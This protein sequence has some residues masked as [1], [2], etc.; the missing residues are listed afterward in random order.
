LWRV[1]AVALIMEKNIF[2][3]NFFFLS[4]HKSSN[5]NSAMKQHVF[6]IGIYYRGHHRKGIAIYDTN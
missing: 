5:C 2:C 1:E 3:H 4:L 6:K